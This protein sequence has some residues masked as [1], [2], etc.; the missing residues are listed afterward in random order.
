IKGCNDPTVGASKLVN[1]AEELGSEDNITAMVIRFPGW[2]SEMP[3]H[4]KDLR[5]YRLE[6]ESRAH[7]RRT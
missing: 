2:G 5:K 3:D 4:T 6:N 7:N 1:F